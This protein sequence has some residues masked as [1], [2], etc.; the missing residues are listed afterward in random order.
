MRV[1]CIYSTFEGEGVRIGKPETIIRLQGCVLPGGKNCSSCDTPEAINPGGGK[2]MD[3][4]EIVE[5]VSVL[6]Q[7]NIHLSGGEPLM[8][9]DELIKL[10]K[11]LVDG[12]E[13]I[14]LETSGLIIDYEV[15]SYCSFLSFDIKTPSTGITI[16]YK[17]LNELTEIEESAQFKMVVK[18]WQ[19]YNFVKKIYNRYKPIWDERGNLVITPCWEVGKELGREFVKKLCKQILADKISVRV[20]LQQHKLLWGSTTRE[21]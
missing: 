4:R 9:R 12:Y 18:N 15:F 7:E 2:E 19:D 10:L 8:Q 20:I 1:N 17:I 6:G 11:L 14:T 16:D 13:S 3:V 21:I 5:R